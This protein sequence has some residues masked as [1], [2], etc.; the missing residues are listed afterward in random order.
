MELNGKK[1][2]I[3]RLNLLE[4][5]HTFEAEIKSQYMQ[6]VIAMASLIKDPK[7]RISVQSQAIKEMPKGKEL[8]ETINTKLGSF[9]GGKKLL[10]IALNKLNSIS[11]KEIEAIII[12]PKHTAS[13]K[14][15]MDYICGSDVEEEEVKEEIPEGAVKIDIG[16]DE[17]KVLKTV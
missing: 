10:H 13:V 9:E 15:I 3:Q 7:E 8:E 2:K 12:D 14:A 11:E 4:I 6:D 17:K 16:D 1:Y 5:Y